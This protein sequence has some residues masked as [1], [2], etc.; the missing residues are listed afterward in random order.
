MAETTALD[1]AEAVRSLLREYAK[2]HGWDR[3]DFAIHV[4]LGDYNDVRVRFASREL[5]D[6]SKR[7]AINEDVYE[8]LRSRLSPKEF[9]RISLFGGRPISQF[10]QT[11]FDPGFDEWARIVEEE[12]T[13]RRGR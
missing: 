4:D 12:N 13:L 5:D 7:V 10:R 11:Y 6:D 3:R 1:T 9:G 8:F 2:T